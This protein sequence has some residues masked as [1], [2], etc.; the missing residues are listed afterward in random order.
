VLFTQG[1]WGE[2][3][4]HE[5]LLL[6][7]PLGFVWPSLNPAW[8]ASRAA[9]ASARERY[10]PVPDDCAQPIAANFSISTGPIGI[11]FALDGA[12]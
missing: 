4:P 1:Q 3:Q 11:V 8:A 7:L 2:R 6:L 12:P 10:L 5:S 9:F